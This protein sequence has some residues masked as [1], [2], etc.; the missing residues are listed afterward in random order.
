MLSGSTHFCRLRLSAAL[1][2]CTSPLL[3][4]D[5]EKFTEYELSSCCKQ[6]N[7]HAFLTAWIQCG[8]CLHVVVMSGVHCTCTRAIWPFHQFMIQSNENV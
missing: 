3:E 5:E 1:N 6:F 8:R 4:G 7:H 2:S